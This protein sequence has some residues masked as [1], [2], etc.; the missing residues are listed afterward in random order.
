M[1]NIG[2][3]PSS[4]GFTSVGF[5]QNTTTKSVQTQSGRSIRATNATTLW[6]GTLAFPPMSQAEFRPIQAFIAL[7]QGRLNEFDIVIPTVSTS[8]SPNAGTVIASVDDDSATQ[9]KSGAT[10][11]N[12]TTNIA[13]G[14]AFKAGDVVRFANHTKVYMVTTDCNTTPSGNATLNIQPALVEDLTDGETL[15]T[16]DVPFRMHLT[17]DVQEYQYATNNLVN[18]EIDVRE[19]L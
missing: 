9:N 19:V 10:E 14:N 16:N 12:I 5:Q 17:N 4:P 1:A 8:Q 15:T 7:A 11:I 13:S 18:Y 6:S 2:T 3:F